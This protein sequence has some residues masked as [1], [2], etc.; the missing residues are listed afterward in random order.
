MSPDTLLHHALTHPLMALLVTL[1]PYGLFTTLQKHFG[2]HS[3]LN[4]V[5]WSIGT[6]V[7]FIHFTPMTYDL[8]RE[9]THPIHLLLGPVTV[10]LAIPLYR[11][12]HVIRQ[13]CFAIGIAIIFSCF[14]AAFSAV[15][16]CL[17]MA[18][19]QEMALAIAS[20]SVTAP[21]AIEIAKKIGT[22]ESLAVFFVFTTGIPGSLLA[23]A[24]FRLCRITDERAQGVALGTTCHGLGTARAFQISEKAGTY[25]ILGMSLMGILSGLILPAL[26]LWLF[27]S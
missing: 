4:P 12:F 24:L 17:F 20:K 14:F 5:I 19:S 15:G 13:D 11:L 3:L 22:P 25:A 1:C 7:A 10:A 8:Y 18:G 26:L 2:G 23:S 21:I 27:K 9:G 16:L 6:C